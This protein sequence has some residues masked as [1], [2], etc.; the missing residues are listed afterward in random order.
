MSSYFVE[1][2]YLIRVTNMQNVITSEGKLD[3][4]K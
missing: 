2:K 3:S 1:A 4:P